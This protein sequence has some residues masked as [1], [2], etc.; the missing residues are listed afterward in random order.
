VAVELSTEKCQVK[1]ALI[2]KPEEIADDAKLH[3]FVGQMRPVLQIF[4]REDVMNWTRVCLVYV[5]CGFSFFAP[6]AET[7]GA[8]ESFVTFDVPGST[9]LPAFPKCTSP[10]AINQERAVTGVYADANAARHSFLR[11]SNGSFITFDPP[12]STCTFM[13]SMCS[14]PTGINPAG[15]IFGTYCD[16]IRCHGFLR[17]ADGTFTTVDPPGSIFTFNISGGINPAGVVTGSYA[18]AS[19][20]FHG[21]VRAGDGTFTTFDPLGST[22]T[23][24]AGINPNGAIAGNYTDASSAQHGFLRA[25]QGAITTFDPP[26]SVFTVVSSINPAGAITGNYQDASS[27]Q[28]GFLRARDGTFT[29]FDPPGI[30][31]NAETAPSGIN[32]AGVITGSY[33]TNTGFHG[34][35]RAAD[36]TFTTFDPPGSID[37]FPNGINPARVIT[38]S[39]I[40]A[41]FL[42]HGFI[43]TSD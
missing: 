17:A 37:T 24:P 5:I 14:T 20:V 8:S 23:S 43:R 9:C 22:G 30:S 28:H 11:T 21:F 1:T 13:F 40:D 4:H 25:A 7:A 29:T 15:V 42:G 38:G 18:D 33:V 16:G 3:Q 34:F 32:P 12:G 26:G 41:E 36:G 19:F 6:Q 31:T 27:L 39:Y 2:R 35:L 10:L